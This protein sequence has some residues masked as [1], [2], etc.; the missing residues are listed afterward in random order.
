MSCDEKRKR[1]NKRERWTIWQAKE[2]GQGKT[3][4]MR[5]R[6]GM[7]CTCERVR[8]G[9]Q[10]QKVRAS[11]QK[12]WERDRWVRVS[13]G[14]LEGGGVWHWW[15]GPHEPEKLDPDQ[16]MSL[17]NS[18]WAEHQ[19]AGLRSDILALPDGSDSVAWQLWQVWGYTAKWRGGVTATPEQLVT[20]CSFSDQLGVRRGRVAS[21]CTAEHTHLS[22]DFKAF[23]V[24]YHYSTKCF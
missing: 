11:E 21:W 14:K 19:V 2:R 12:K 20:H 10:Q 23:T 17:W 22:Q 9:K 4:W 3:K 1:H 18:S 24:Y 15:T 7:E 8:K 5:W 6:E 16:S 13:G